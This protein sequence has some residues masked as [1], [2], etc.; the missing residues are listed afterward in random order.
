MLNLGK[1][2]NS[3][4]TQLTTY[5]EGEKLISYLHDSPQMREKQ[6][7]HWESNLED[8]LIQLD[9]QIQKERITHSTPDKLFILYTICR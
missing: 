3:C 7:S 5:N 9:N 8:V 1:S 6:V 4:S 2:A